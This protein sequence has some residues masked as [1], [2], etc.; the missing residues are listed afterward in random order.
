MAATI[1]FWRRNPKE[2]AVIRATML[3]RLGLLLG[4]IAATEAAAELAAAQV[5]CAP[6][7]YYDPLYGCLIAGEAYV[8]PIYPFEGYYGYAAPFH[9]WG[10]FHRPDESAHG[11]YMGPF[12]GGGG[13]GHR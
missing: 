5:A 8:Q 6:G 13:H 4:V 9:A 11:A 7:Y 1:A 10:R 12:V 3:I 2:V